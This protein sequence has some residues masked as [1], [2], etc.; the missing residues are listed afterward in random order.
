MAG[1]TG[2]NQKEERTLRTYYKISDMQIASLIVLGVATGALAVGL[3]AG[4][5][6]PFIGLFTG[7]GPVNWNEA[8]LAAAAI[9]LFAAATTYGVVALLK[10]R[11]EVTAEAIDEARDAA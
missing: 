2:N 4:M 11:A 7:A 10:L 9:T 5:V 6:P 1:D 3:F 8:S